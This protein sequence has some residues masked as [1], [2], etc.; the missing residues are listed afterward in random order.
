VY[1]T[2]AFQANFDLVDSDWSEFR[3]AHRGGWEGMG[4]L[5][6]RDPHPY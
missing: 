5:S 4:Y 6:V 2:K 1:T 3:E